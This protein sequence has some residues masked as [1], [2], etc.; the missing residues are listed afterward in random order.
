[1]T[2][3]KAKTKT[4]LKIDLDKPQNPNPLIVSTY[5]KYPDLWSTVKIGD[6]Y[7]SAEWNGEKRFFDIVDNNEEDKHETLHTITAIY[8]RQV[9]E[10]LVCWFNEHL[11]NFDWNSNPIDHT[12][13]L[14]KFSLPRIHNKMTRDNKGNKQYTPEIM[15]HTTIYEYDWEDL[16][17]QLVQWHDKGM[18]DESIQYIVFDSNGQKYS[19]PYS[20]Q[21]FFDLNMESLLLLGKYGRKLEGVVT[22][23]NTAVALIKESLTQSIKD[24]NQVPGPA[25][26]KATT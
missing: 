16:K 23:P 25:S 13:T 7:L 17:E 1:M 14:G 11:Q 6:F 9:G 15:D 12:R 22:D 19:K 10:R 2:T 4:K 20:Y 26:S 8:K 24:I 5:E 18:F 3:T 21:E